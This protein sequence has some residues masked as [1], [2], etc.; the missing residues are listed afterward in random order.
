MEKQRETVI[1]GESTEKKPGNEVEIRA[2]RGY[3]GICIYIYMHMWEWK[4]VVGQ[5][6]SWEMGLEP[7][8]LHIE[9]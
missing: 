4:N 6:S 2:L 5:T 3:R 8:W 9:K 7:C 1:N